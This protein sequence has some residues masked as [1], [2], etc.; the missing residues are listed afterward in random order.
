MGIFTKGP[1]YSEKSMGYQKVKNSP[2][3]KKI[4][5]DEGVAKAIDEPREREEVYRKLKEYEK[6]GVTKEELQ[7]TFAFFRSGKGK[8]VSEKEGYEIARKMMPSASDRYKYSSSWDCGT[9]SKSQSSKTG[10]SES[11]SSKGKAPS[12]VSRVASSAVAPTKATARNFSLAGK[13]A[14]FSKTSPAGSNLGA[15][16]PSFSQALRSTLFK[17]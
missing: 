17:K 11:I 13:S 5:S 14:A 16:K 10:A 9:A 7:R 1:V 15:S 6:G 8:F 2:V 12:Q 3:M 4:L